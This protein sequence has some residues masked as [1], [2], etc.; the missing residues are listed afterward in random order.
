[1]LR[2]RGEAAPQSLPPVGETRVSARVLKVT[3]SQAGSSS[4]SSAARLVRIR[5]A[6]SAFENFFSFMARFHL[7]GEYRLDRVR[8]DF[9]VETFLAQPAIEG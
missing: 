5:R 7:A 1:M 6:I 4:R 9:F 2:D 3:A 8:C